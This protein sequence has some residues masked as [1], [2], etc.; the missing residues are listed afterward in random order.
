MF[1]RF[2]LASLVISGFACAVPQTAVAQC[3]DCCSSTHSCGTCSK[4]CRPNHTKIIYR[5]NIFGSGF[6][7]AA[8]PQNFLVANS[9][10]AMMVSTP[11]FAATPAFAVTPVAF[12]A[13]APVQAAPASPAAAAA[14]DDKKCPDACGSILQLRKDVDD[15]IAVTNKLTLA[16]EKL[17][18]LQ[19]K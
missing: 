9:A 4:C 14:A 18:E 19:K 17:A 10:P 7:G 6:V 3:S 15:L 13:A 2:L 12:A 16:V 5:R 8:P 1:P 11:A